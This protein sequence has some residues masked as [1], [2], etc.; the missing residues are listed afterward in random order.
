M[1]RAPSFSGPLSAKKTEI[2]V[3]LTP[4]WAKG[5]GHL[6]RAPLSLELGKQE[7]SRG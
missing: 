6:R 5:E 3:K 4:A 2:C 1:H 7:V